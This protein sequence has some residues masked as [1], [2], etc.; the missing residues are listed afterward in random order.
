MKKLKLLLGVLVCCFMMAMPE[1]QAQIN[2]SS[3][4]VTANSIDSLNN[5]TPN[6]SEGHAVLGLV[7]APDKSSRF[8][9]WNDSSDVWDYT[10]GGSTELMVND[11]TTIDFTYNG[12]ILTAEIAQNGAIA[13]Q[14]LQWDGSSWTPQD[15]I[16]S[17]VSITDTGTYYTT[18]NVEAA[19][20]ELG[21]V[22]QNIVTAENTYDSDADAAAG[23]PVVPIGGHYYLSISNVYGGI[24][25]TIRKRKN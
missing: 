24:E 25:N 1:G 12:G 6:Y 8:A 13:N 16:G 22:V 11:G 23:S 5:I 19:L 21:A 3:G 18:D 7:I 10:T 15:Q 2:A 17:E 4:I 9:I 14:T 20:Q